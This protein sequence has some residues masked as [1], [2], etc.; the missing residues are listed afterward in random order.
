[1]YGMKTIKFFC[2]LFLL[3]Q[4]PALLAQQYEVKTIFQLLGVANKKRPLN[5][6][7]PSQKDDRREYSEAVMDDAIENM[8]TGE[9]LLKST[10]M[11]AG[12]LLK[13]PVSKEPPA[14]FTVYTF[15]FS[16]PDYS[17]LQYSAAG[18]EAVKYI[19][20]GTRNL[21]SFFYTSQPPHN[22]YGFN[23]FD[24]KKNSMYFDGAGKLVF[25]HRFQYV[26]EME[27][28]YYKFYE[29][30]KTGI[31][32]STGKI[33]LPAK[34]DNAVAYTFRGKPWFTV[35][36]GDKS[37]FL[38]YGKTEPVMKNTTGNPNIIPDFIDDR[39]WLLYGR[40]FDMQ[41]RE[42]LF[43][44]IEDEI[45]IKTE[46]HSLFF[47]KRYLRRYGDDER[48]QSKRDREE[49][50]FFDVNGNL[51]LGQ[52]VRESDRVGDSSYI[53]RVFYK[54]TI[55][56]GEEFT[57]SKYGLAA[58]SGKWIK[59]P[60]YG[61]MNDIDDADAI[62]F[63]T[64]FTDTTRP[65][66]MDPSGKILIPEGKYLAFDD[67]GKPGKFVCYNGSTSDLWDA[68]TNTFT[69]LPKNF[70]DIRT[71]LGL[72]DMGF[73]KAT[74]PRSKVY[75]LDSNYHLSDTT[76][77]ADVDVS[78]GSKLLACFPFV[79]G[80]KE[81][82]AEKY[83]F[84]PSLQP[85]TV[86]YDG[87][88]YTMFREIDSLAPG[89]YFYRFKND[90]NIVRTKEG[91]YFA[92]SCIRVEYDPFFN[93][94]IGRSHRGTGILDNKGNELLSFSFSEI[95]N[96]SPLYRTASLS[97]D[98]EKKLQ[99]LD[100]KGNLLFNGEYDRVEP[101]TADHFMVEKNGV[102]GLLHRSGMV[103]I[104]VAHQYLAAKYGMIWYGMSEYATTSIPI[105][106]LAK[107]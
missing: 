15:G 92:T 58:S 6:P 32:D 80:K 65:G 79:D 86:T 105:N 27:G 5:D 41:T 84:T 25:D 45:D 2:C 10:T 18:Y 63:I 4:S 28:R 55:I 29:G 85:V 23:A 20:K 44:N 24:E 72:R 43:C 83:F 101:V 96:Y 30:R 38:E 39:Y 102:R 33:I 37:W 31:A 76:A 100:E 90:N 22:G 26:E 69:R 17:L 70:Y 13:H 12:W 73:M 61:Y 71:Y 36:D 104:P 51:L 97:Y 78:Y 16:Y 95:G 57:L 34:Y 82:D 99:Q 9:S 54:D 67:A 35:K 75:L 64:A 56:K 3:V 53:I 66:L 49:E 81:Y 106:E 68:A 42:E 60:V 46:D 62:I 107:K 88:T 74:A 59:K 50:I 40:V 14:P 8:T 48:P 89:V 98:H 94:Y 103:I 7:A 52:P 93:W 77:W 21:G 19:G 47:I 87:M 11:L 91:N 1:M